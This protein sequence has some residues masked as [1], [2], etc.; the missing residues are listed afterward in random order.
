ML[1]SG[2]SKPNKPGIKEPLPDVENGPQA[3]CFGGRAGS[4]SGGEFVLRIQRARGSRKNRTR[5]RSRKE[6]RLKE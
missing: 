1:A 4:W 6:R 3:H 2:V 5:L